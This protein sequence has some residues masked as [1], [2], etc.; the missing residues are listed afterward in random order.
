[1]RAYTRYGPHKACPLFFPRTEKNREQ[2][3]TNTLFTQGLIESDNP[4]L[5]KH[6]ANAQTIK[7][8][9]N[10]KTV[11]FGD[12]SGD[13][14]SDTD[15]LAIAAQNIHV[16]GPDSNKGGGKGKHKQKQRKLKER[17][18]PISYQVSTTAS[19]E[20][21]LKTT[22]SKS[23]AAAAYARNHRS[24]RHPT[25][26]SISIMVHVSPNSSW[27]NSPDPPNN[28]LIEGQS[29]DDLIIRHPSITPAPQ[30]SDPLNIPSPHLP[31]LPTKSLNI[32]TSASPSPNRSSRKVQRPTY[33]RV[34]KPKGPPLSKKVGRVKKEK[35]NPQGALI[36]PKKLGLNETTD[37]IGEQSMLFDES[38]TH[39]DSQ[40]HMG[41][42]FYKDNNLCPRGGYIPS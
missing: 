41:I 13:Y 6:C 40:L 12:M 29:T 2:C 30:N 10:E 23:S 39:D 26:T 17:P 7:L 38:L 20:E 27:L 32:S 19:N 5:T 9:V 8:G 25:K 18:L 31:Q 34:R 33:S 35:E 28:K 15:I 3:T 21:Q 37:N 4:R 22:T 14:E 11:T 1:M 42:F 24:S 36:I 16:G